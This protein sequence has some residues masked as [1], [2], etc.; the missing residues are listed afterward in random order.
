MIM[1]TVSICSLLTFGL[2]F[3]V[4]A[5]E[6]LAPTPFFAQRELASPP[7][8]AIP[9]GDTRIHGGAFDPPFRD[10]A[11]EGGILVGFEAG[12]GS[13]AGHTVINALEPIYRTPRG[14]FSSQRYGKNQ[15]RDAVVTAKPGYAVGALTARTGLLV[16]GIKMHFM[17]VTGGKLNPNDS[18]QSEWIG[19]TTGG[20]DGILGGEGA[21]IVGVIGT[22]NPKNGLTG[23]GLA[24]KSEPAPAKPAFEFKG[25]ISYGPGLRTAETQLLGATR[26]LAGLNGDPF[27]DQAPRGAMLVGL[28]I[29]L[30]KANGKDFISSIQ[31]HYRTATDDVP[32]KKYGDSSSKVVKVQAK[33]GYAICGLSVKSGTLVDSIKVNFMRIAG[34]KLTANDSYQ[35]EWI[36]AAGS[37]AILL[38]GDGTPVVGLIG[39]ASPNEL[40]GLGLVLKTR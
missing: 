2:Y 6:P 5:D 28:D 17:R 9:S 26:I 25:P 8:K 13:F 24:F 16:N 33:F 34:P 4:A 3:P 30:G 20:A 1:Q 12:Y 39:K 15:K 11:P 35:G 7:K 14:E 32:G 38:G 23:I 40:T 10:E 27:R 22:T 31:P 18:Y 37:S 36:G 29:G 19:G 21:L